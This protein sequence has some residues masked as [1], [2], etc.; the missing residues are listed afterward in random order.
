MHGIDF[1]D[2]KHIFKQE[3][4]KMQTVFSRYLWNT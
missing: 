4:H 1:V 2:I 3:L